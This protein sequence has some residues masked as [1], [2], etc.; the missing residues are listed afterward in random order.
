V[1]IGDSLFIERLADAL[2]QNDWSLE[3]SLPIIKTLTRGC[4]LPASASDR[5]HSL[6]TVT[7]HRIRERLANDDLLGDTL[8]ALLPRYEG[9]SLTLYRGEN[10][11]RWEQGVVG[12]AW[13]QDIEVA[14]MFARG[15]QALQGGGGVLLTV[16]ASSE[17]VIAEP[18]DHS[19]NWLGEGEY[20]VDSRHLDDIRV[21]ER[22]PEWH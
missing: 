3:E 4:P 19:R 17:A 2:A 22:F 21:I 20:V 8:R 10:A 14:T 12:F 6:W 1:L 16:E 7:G 18:N 15:L 11:E 13:T 5:F 9:P